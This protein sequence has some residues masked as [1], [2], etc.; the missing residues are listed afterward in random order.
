MTSAYRRQRLK[1]RGAGCISGAATHAARRGMVLRCIYHGSGALTIECGARV[2]LLQRQGGRV[3]GNEQAMRGVRRRR[4]A[5]GGRHLRCRRR[6]AAAA[7]RARRGWRQRAARK[8]SGGG[9]G[10]R[11]YCAR[12]GRGPRV[13]ALWSGW[14]G[15]GSAGT[16]LV[17]I[18]LYLTGWW[19]QEHTITAGSTP[20]THSAAGQPELAARGSAGKPC[21]KHAHQPSH[22]PTGLS[23][24]AVD[25]TVAS[26]RRRHAQRSQHRWMGGA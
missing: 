10:M 6:R 7:G 5:A 21:N 3:S 19:L 23:W 9:G 25:D 22:H 16:R 4:R 20:P 8:L 13:M 24:R 1:C 17:K 2:Q 12:M 11:L 18:A 26:L 14:E 15:C